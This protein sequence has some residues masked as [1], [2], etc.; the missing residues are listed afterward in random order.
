MCGLLVSKNSTRGDSIEHVSKLAHPLRDHP[1][2]V[3]LVVHEAGV[4]VRPHEQQLQGLLV[5]RL[6]GEM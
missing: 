5:V 6:T 2:G 4:D 1:G 3:A